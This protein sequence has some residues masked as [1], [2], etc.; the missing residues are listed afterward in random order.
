MNEYSFIIWEQR[1]MWT[2]LLAAFFS[3]ATITIITDE[4]IT[5]QI[6]F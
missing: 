3:E 1:R 6:L 5:E 4:D 2:D